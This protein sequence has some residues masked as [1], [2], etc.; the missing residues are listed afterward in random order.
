MPIRELVQAFY[1]RFWNEVEL[2]LADEILH[3]EVTFRGSVGVGATGRRAVCDYVLLVTT[4]LSEYRCD[5]ESLIV[6]GD[7]AAAKVR[8]SGLHTVEFL[9]YAPT[10]RHVE[11]IG[12]AF[13]TAEGDTLRD[14]WVLGDLESLRSQL[15]I[16]PA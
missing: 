10:G 13:F 9:G 12:A 1:E 11:W 2:S 7:R 14:I 16:P 5:V 4:A 15:A 8:F 3:P 6:E